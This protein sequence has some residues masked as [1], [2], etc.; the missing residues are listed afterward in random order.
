MADYTRTE[1]DI[2]VILGAI[3]VVG[4]VSHH[5]VA[6]NKKDVCKATAE[7]EGLFK[8]AVNVIV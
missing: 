5:P 7:P 2:S 6:T 3:K 4:V 1:V 8:V